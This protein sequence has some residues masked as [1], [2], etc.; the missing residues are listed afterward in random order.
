MA[1][2]PKEPSGPNHFARQVNAKARRKR[3][4]QRHTNHTIWFGFGMMGIVGWSVAIPTV[5]GGALGL[6]LDD[7]YPGGR[8][9]TLALLLGGLALGCITALYWLKNEE[10]A[11]KEEPDDDDD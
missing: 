5:L 6:W 11:M 2:S 9:W 10:Q 1:E 8:S 3:Q 4:A 7:L